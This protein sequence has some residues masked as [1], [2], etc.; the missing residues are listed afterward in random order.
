MSLRGAL[1]T[2]AVWVVLVVV[3]ASRAGAATLR[4][5][6]DQPS[7]QVA[8]DAA[9]D[10]DSVVVAAGTYFERIDF[11]RK[12]ITVVSESGPAATI[13]DGGSSGSVVSFITAE[14]ATSVLEGFTIQHGRA[15]FGSGG[16]AGGGIHINRASPTVRGN[17]IRDNDGCNGAGVLISSASPLVERNVI[18]NNRRSTCEGGGGGG[19]VAIM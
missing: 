7:I 9:S 16:F 10:G 12:A 14:R 5:P 13:I 6:D 2:S 4:V 17:V 11:H 3:G 18:T 19:G 15:Y 1:R 8:I